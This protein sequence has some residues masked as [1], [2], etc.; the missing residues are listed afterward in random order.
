[1]AT[2]EKSLRRKVGK[3]TGIVSA[4]ASC[5]AGIVLLSFQTCDAIKSSRAANT[6]AQAS[7][8]KST[9][10]YDTLLDLIEELQDIAGDDDE[11][12]G[13]TDIEIY[14]L[15]DQVKALEKS[16]VKY[17][18]YFE[19][20]KSHNGD[21]RRYSDTVAE[22]E[23]PDSHEAWHKRN[24]KKTKAGKPALKA[25]KSLEDAVQVQQAL[26]D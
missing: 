25:P 16:H 8:V 3:W 6:A 20:L 17:E 14:N 12:S 23:D 15:Q 19:M 4:V 22:Y 7:E 13:E 10:G 5:I 24:D 11:W 21:L 18:A 9:V 26:L 1:M 2:G